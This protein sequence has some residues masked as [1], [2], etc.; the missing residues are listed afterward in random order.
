MDR[1]V[2]IATDDLH[3]SAY[4]GFLVVSLDRQEQGR[5]ALDDI[6]AVIVHAHGVTWTTSLVV[7][8]AEHCTILVPCTYTDTAVA[9]I[10]PI[11]GHHPR[12]ARI[13]AKVDAA[14]PLF[15]QL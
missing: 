12:A 6:Q 14:R 9:F 8:L 11:D 4:R 1:I 3:L 2:D 10:S 15:K 7:A 5:V 13:R